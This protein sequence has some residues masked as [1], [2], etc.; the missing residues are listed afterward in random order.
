MPD[1]TS[2]G[3]LIPEFLPGRTDHFPISGA[4]RGRNKAGQQ[5]GHTQ[6]GQKV[7]PAD[8]GLAEDVEARVRRR[9]CRGLPGFGQIAVIRP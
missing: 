3:N 8:K 2:R 5:N 9:L 1:E 6:S 7:P 4:A